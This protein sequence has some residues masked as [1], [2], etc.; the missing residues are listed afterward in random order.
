[1]GNVLECASDP[2]TDLADPNTP[3]LLQPP[4]RLNDSLLWKLNTQFYQDV[5]EKAWTEN[6]VPHF[7]SNNSF[8][9][10]SYATV[11]LEFLNDWFQDDNQQAD[12]SEPVYIIEFGAGIGK[13]GYLIIKELLN[14]RAFFPEMCGD[15]IPF[16]YVLTDCASKTIDFWNNHP[17]FQPLF[18]MGVLETALVDVNVPGLGTFQ[19]KCFQKLKILNYGSCNRLCSYRQNS[20]FHSS[21]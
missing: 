19:K 8:I 4:T 1:M 18:E 17:Q 10:K 11:I 3:R 20:I 16:R 9:A 13:L 15:N 7:V 2:L 6:I 12:P 21:L 5:G 14:K